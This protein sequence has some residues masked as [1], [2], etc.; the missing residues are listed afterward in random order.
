MKNA[1]LLSR[2]LE[3]SKYYTV[4]SD[5]HRLDSTLGAGVKALVDEQDVEVG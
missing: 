5:I 4:L 3:S 2:A 1:R